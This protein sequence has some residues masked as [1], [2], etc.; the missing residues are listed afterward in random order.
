M[1]RG[2]TDVLIRHLGALRR[3]ADARAVYKRMSLAALTL[4]AQRGVPR[5]TIEEMQRVL[6]LR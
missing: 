5:E 3:D 6:L 4:A 2:E 1:V